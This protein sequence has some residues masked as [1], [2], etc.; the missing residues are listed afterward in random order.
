MLVAAMLCVVLLAAGGPAYAA[1]GW[2]WA[3]PAPDSGATVLQIRTDSTADPILTDSAGM[4]VPWSIGPRRD[5]DV[6]TLTP[7]VLGAGTYTLTL[8]GQSRSIT[9]EGVDFASLAAPAGPAVTGESPFLLFAG[10]GLVLLIVVAGWALAA[11]RWGRRRALAISGALVTLGVLGLAFAERQGSTAISQA[12]ASVD[13]SAITRVYLGCEDQSRDYR[14]LSECW[15]RTSAKVISIGGVDAARGILTS[16]ADSAVR[17]CHEA[18]HSLGRAAWFATRDVAPIVASGIPARC[19]EGFV[20]GVMEG[21]SQSLDVEALSRAL[22]ALCPLDPS[23]SDVQQR[24]D[25]RRLCLHGAGHAFVRRA[26]GDLERSLP[27]CTYWKGREMEAC[28]TGAVMEWTRMKELA[29][30]SSHTPAGPSDPREACL[31]VHPESR[32]ELIDCYT[33]TASSMLVPDPV[34][35]TDWCTDHDPARL[36]ACILGIAGSFTAYTDDMSK[37]AANCDRLGAR[38]DACVTLGAYLVANHRRVGFEEMCTVLPVGRRG[39][40]EDGVRRYLR[41]ILAN[42]GS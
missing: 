40:C 41:E 9:R 34:V 17:F 30:G 13:A 19:R 26:G 2:D 24:A 42:G 1:G 27:G 39:I 7:P 11:R 6:V 3:G 22:D 37:I 35:L 29:G 4:V 32:D 31:L 36:D 18:G 28:Q 20:H 38:A 14:D 15:D 16:T 21:A 33:A 12:T 25:R 5:G 8:D 23:V 10:A